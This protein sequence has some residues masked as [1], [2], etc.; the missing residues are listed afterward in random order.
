MADHG[1]KG[2]APADLIRLRSHG[3]S[4]SYVGALHSLGYTRLSADDLVRLRSHGISA[5]FVRRINA[6]GR[7]SVDNLVRLRTGG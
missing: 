7:Q 4:A 5:D 2:L 1:I 6:G 3:V